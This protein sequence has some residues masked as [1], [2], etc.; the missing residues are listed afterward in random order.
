MLS[1]EM[2][3]LMSEVINNKSLP[4]STMGSLRV[5]S[6]HVIPQRGRGYLKNSREQVLF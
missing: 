5:Y 4:A 1:F 6:Q 3:N 2:Q